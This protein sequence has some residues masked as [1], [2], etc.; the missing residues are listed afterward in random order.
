MVWQRLWSGH[1]RCGCASAVSARVCWSGLP[2]C[3]TAAAGGWGPGLVCARELLE[4]QPTA[5]RRRRGH[6][7]TAVASE[8]H[9][10]G[11]GHLAG[12]GAAMQEICAM[13]QQK[14]ASGAVATK[15]W[16]EAS[17]TG[18]KNGSAGSS[19]AASAGRR[20]ASALLCFSGQAHCP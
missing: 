14:M 2:V 11:W 8:G 20:F 10:L 9:Q 17:A 4:G 18:G 3:S 19:D 13:T 12:C 6:L 1:G 16:E 5:A 7:A 15:F